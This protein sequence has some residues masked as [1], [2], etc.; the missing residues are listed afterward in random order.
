MSVEVVTL[1]STIGAGF[2][3]LAWSLMSRHEEQGRVLVARSPYTAEALY[4]TT[5]FLALCMINPTRIENGQCV[6][7][8]IH[9]M[10][11]YSKTSP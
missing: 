1:K 10:Q 8:C 5:S 9:A 3:A 2:T 6:C 7:V 11:I 4:R